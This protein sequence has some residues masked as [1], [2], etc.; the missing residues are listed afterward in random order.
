MVATLSLVFLPTSAAKNVSPDFDSERLPL[1]LLLGAQWRW[2][3]ASLASSDLGICISVSAKANMVVRTRGTTTSM[4]EALEALQTGTRDGEGGWHLNTALSTVQQ[5]NIVV[6]PSDS[7]FFVAEMVTAATKSSDLV[8]VNLSEQ[9]LQQQYAVISNVFAGA[10]AR[11]WN[12]IAAS[13]SDESPLP[14]AGA[15]TIGARLQAVFAAGPDYPAG[16]LTSGS[17]HRPGLIQTSDLTATVADYFGVAVPSQV[18][19]KPVSVNS[20]SAAS[21]AANSDTVQARLASD[22]RRAA[23]I[24]PTQQ[25]FL[26]VYGVLL[27]ATLLGGVWSLNR[28]TH[29]LGESWSMPRPLLN[30]WRV[31][32][33]GM[34]LVP[35]MAFWMN[36]APWWNVGPAETDTAVAVFA[37]F[38]AVLP[39]LLA[40]AVTAIWEYSGM[41]RRVGSVL[42][43]GGVSL[44]VGLVNPLTGSRL[45]LDAV[46]GHQ[47]TIGARFYGMDNMMFAVFITGAFLVAAATYTRF[48][49]GALR[50][51]VLGILLAFSLVVIFF[52]ASPLL[53]ADFGGILVTVPSF[54]VLFLKLRS[55]K[56]KPFSLLAV[57]FAGV[58]VATLFAWWDWSRPAQQRTHLGG[59]V[60][61]VLSG[62]LLTVIAEKATS[63]WRNAEWSAWGIGLGFMLGAVM[64]A[65]VL[66]PLLVSHRRGR[67][68]DYRWLLGSEAQRRGV[69]VRWFAGERAFVWAW[70]CAMI[71]AALFNDSSVL[72][73]LAG[74]AVAGPVML[75]HATRRV[76]CRAAVP[77][78]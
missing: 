26:V 20:G 60:D 55:R 25:V 40:A 5:R 68:G 46:I 19:G 24:I 45:M 58:V 44:A 9:P 67:R 18:L 17:T 33:C 32:G 74:T 12:V 77:K 2:D 61:S 71:L 78:Q 3:D 10:Q 8:V 22:A 66:V 23:I 56:L 62:Q 72:I 47:S 13:I 28:R 70:G 49:S 1:V 37:W 54:A 48:D 76:L 39:L 59:F 16:V 6:K 64:L 29:R 51:P 30:L 73:P 43:V 27:A 7:G 31:V 42:L 36:L 65:A 11:N 75:S 14:S 4:D 38:G 63:M 41:A 15:S 57:V 34:A 52:D 21:P 69:R 53:G 50:V 35:A